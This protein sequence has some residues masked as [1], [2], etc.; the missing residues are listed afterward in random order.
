[1]SS[2]VAEGEEHVRKAEKYLKTSFLKWSPD[3]DSAGDEYSR[4]ATSFKVAREMDRT[5]DCLNKA[6]ECYKMIKSLYSAAKML[7]Q[8]VL[9]CRDTNQL[10]KIVDYA[11]RGGMLYRQN[12]NPEAAAQLLEKAA[13]ILEQKHPDKALTLYTHAAET[14]G[15]EGRDKEASELLTKVAKLQVK[16]KMWDKAKETIRQTIAL[17]T[18][19]GSTLLTGRLVGGLVLVELAREDTVAANKSFHELEGWCD[20]DLRQGVRALLQAYEEMDPEAA[21]KALA[22]PGIRNLDIEFARMAAKDIPLPEGEDLEAAAAAYGAER[23]AAVDA[24]AAAVAAASLSE[25][26]KPAPAEPA[27]PAREPEPAPAQAEE[28]DDDEDEGLC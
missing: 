12:G 10:D 4:A 21:K 23:A 22:S 14:V 7:E 11:E 16:S 19:I 9:I 24:A 5:L 6:C 2:K 20:A 18:E 13:K 15:T 26:T 1:M 27:E 28:E 3:Y 17:Q 25:P 8:A